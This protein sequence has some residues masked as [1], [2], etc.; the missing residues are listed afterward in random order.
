MLA[1]VWPQSSRSCKWCSR[2]LLEREENLLLVDFQTAVSVLA[3]NRIGEGKGVGCGGSYTV[4]KVEAQQPVEVDGLLV[5]I[6]L[7]KVVRNSAINS[8]NRLAIGFLA[9][10]VCGYFSV[11]LRQGSE[12]AAGSQW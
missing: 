10:Q 7:A 2:N 1:E 11:I 4:C 12:S 5:G 6:H 3:V 8:G 9:F